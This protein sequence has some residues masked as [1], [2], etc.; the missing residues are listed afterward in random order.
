MPL[1]SISN[2]QRKPL[3]HANFVATVYHGIPADLHRPSFGQGQLPC[4]LGADFAGKAPGSRDQNS[5]CRRHAAED[6]CEGRQ[7]RRRLLPQ[8]YTAAFRWAGVEF[9]GEINER[10]KAKF[11]GEAAA[12]LF[13]VDWP[14]P[15]GLVMIEAMACGTPVLAFRLRLDPRDHR[16]WRHRQDRRQRGRSHR[17]AAGKSCLTTAARCGNGLKRDSPRKRM[18][19][20]Y[21]STYRRLLKTRTSGAKPR[22]L[23]FNGGNGL[24]PISIEKPQRQADADPEIPI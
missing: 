23:D 17:G 21:V 10:E 12:L 11:L 19:K 6:R 1:V 5:A 24:T 20:D 22:Q 16:G 18:A 15:F 8:R 3:P 9:I 14:E 4:L 2:D 13:P 7:G